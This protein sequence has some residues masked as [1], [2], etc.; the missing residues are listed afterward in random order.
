MILKDKHC[1]LSERADHTF[2]IR[3]TGAD[4]KLK[5]M[6]AL[7]DTL[8]RVELFT[9][10]IIVQFVL[11]SLVVVFWK[12]HMK[13]KPNFLHLTK[14][15]NCFMLVN[16]SHLYYTLTFSAHACYRLQQLRPY[17]G[18]IMACKIQVSLL[19]G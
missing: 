4:R 5:L 17:H 14:P 1:E 12:L 8:A 16:S 7:P 19:C 9:M 13:V 15:Q 3:C 18:L 10:N 6:L 2:P 11:R